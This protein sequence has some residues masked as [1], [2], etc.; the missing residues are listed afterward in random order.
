MGGR[1]KLQLEGK[2][3][4]RLTVLGEADGRAD[5]FTWWTCQCDCGNTVDV[6]GV[7]L[8]SGHTKSCGCI[9]RDIVTARNHAGY[10]Q[11]RNDNLRLYR[12]YHGMLS[13]CYN[14]VGDWKHYASYGGRG[15]K[16]C[17]EWRRDFKAFLRWALK[18]GYRDG[19]TIDR[20]NNDGDYEPSNCRWATMSEQNF[21]RRKMG[22]AK[23][24]RLAM[25]G[26]EI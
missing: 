26:K 12:I 21:N 4:G 23:A 16:V 7:S 13:R 8:K 20:I 15:I 11:E 24:E 10:N 6:K 2:R 14:P 3:F 19:L 9:V 1:P 22:V 18:N 17:E 5:G 25:Y